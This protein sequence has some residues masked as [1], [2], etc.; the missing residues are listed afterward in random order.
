[1]RAGQ[2][3]NSALAFG[4]DAP[5]AVSP[6]LS[7]REFNG[8]Q[9]P[10]FYNLDGP[11]KMGEGFGFG[12][13]LM[14]YHPEFLAKWH[15]EAPPRNAQPS[16]AAVLERYKA[17][18]SE[19]PASPL[20]GVVAQITLAAKPASRT[21]YEAWLKT[22]GVTFPIRFIDAGESSEGIKAVEF[23][24][25]HAPLRAETIRFGAHSTIE[26]RMNGTATWKFDSREAPACSRMAAQFRHRAAT[27][28]RL[29]KKPS[30]RRNRLS[31]SPQVT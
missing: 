27:R 8:T 23:R 7:T 4:G 10:W 15:P 17:I 24:L 5:G 13:W 3:R 11:W 31:T 19:K 18:L 6:Q 20:F 26:V 29:R 14:E 30:D 22:I 28:H 21:R 16:R 12:S 2:P 1:M 9:I 25:D